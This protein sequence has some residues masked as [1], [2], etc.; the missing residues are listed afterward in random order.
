MSWA[1]MADWMKDATVMNV[2]ADTATPK[3]R[4]FIVAIMFRRR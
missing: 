2:A 3:R 1:L 4:I